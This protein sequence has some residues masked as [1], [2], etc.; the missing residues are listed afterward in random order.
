M[1][2]QTARRPD[3]AVAVGIAILVV[4][5]FV[6]LVVRPFGGAPGVPAVPRFVDES[7]TAGVATTYDGDATYATGGGLAVLDCDDDGRPDLFVAGGANPAALYRNTS[8][9]GG[10]LRFQAVPDP[11]LDRTGVTGAYPIDVDGDGRPDLAVLRV[12]GVALLRGLGGCRFAEGPAAWGFDGGSGLTTAFSATWEGDAALPTLAIGR[13]LQRA[14]DGSLTQACDTGALIR[15]DASG[16]RF[17]PAVPLSPSFCALSMLFS[18]WNGSGH[19]DLRVSNDRQY[20]V[21][22]S[23]QLW[24]ILAG[25]PP[26]LYTA[27]DGWRPLQIWGM[28]IAS[29]DVTGDGYPDVYLTSQGDN[30]LQTL[31]AGPSQPTYVDIAL[32]RGVTATQPYAGGDALPSTAWHPEFEDVNDDGRM[33]LFVSKG[34]VSAMPD[35]AA[36]D[37]SNLL[38]GQPDD[39]FRESGEEAGLVSFDRGRGAAVADLN[40]DGLPDVVLVNYG[41]PVRVWRNVGGGTAEAPAPMGGWLGVRVSQPGLN[42]DAIGGWLE[43]RIGDAV[44]RRE[45]TIGGGHGSGQLGWLHVGIGSAD[46]ADLRVIWPDGSAGPWQHVDADRFVDLARDAS[47]VEFAPPAP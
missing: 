11:L 42:R 43:T 47:P 2:R 1:A 33:D 5:T 35:Y 27:A 39:T 7:S 22:G 34:N 25:E 17:A 3:A 30:K 41:A 26:R 18:D 10:A 6:L 40:L 8:P 16:A 29:D 23:E 45:L 21:D 32:P 31:A 46:G 14:A 9:T 28:G 24:R 15:P 44:S 20:Y 13:Y 36:K 38:L 4:V 19:Q 37:P 12:D